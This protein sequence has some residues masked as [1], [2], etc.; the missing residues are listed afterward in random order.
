M[1][2]ALFALL[3][4]LGG[5]GGV[6]LLFWPGVGLVERWRRLRQRSARIQTEDALKYL[7]KAELEGQPVSTTELAGVLQVSPDH[8]AAL[9]GTMRGRG[10][11]A[12]QGDRPQLTP[13]G[14]SHALHIVR[15][16]R[17]WERHLADRTGF[18]EHE[19][20]AQAEHVEHLLTP[21]DVR[22]LSAD[23]GYPTHDPHGDPIPGD[24]GAVVPHAGRPLSVLAVDQ[25][26]RIVHVE[27]EPAAVYAQLVAEGLRP[28]MVGRIVEADPD[29]LLVW[30]DGDVHVLAPIL[31]HNVSVVPLADAAEAEPYAA[32]KL[33]SLRPGEGG[34]VVRLSRACRG[35][36]RRR[37]LDLGLT[38][39][40]DVAAELRST[41]GGPTA[42]RIRG[43]LIALRRDQADRI[44]IT[45]TEASS[46]EATSE[47]AGNHEA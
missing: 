38:P 10:L 8:A 17:L 2:D 29:R 25:A 14:R 45:R 22:L 47:P 30:A 40:T 13:E 36:E 12:W 39:G 1:P 33:S 42:Y 5:L 32:E 20:H 6:V 19:W 4:A 18:G 16:H 34:R 7:F 44:H 31:A 28:G 27:D 15:A 11:I 26:F 43:A 41:G 21:A 37:L 24:D 3:A 9:L 23:L 35:A 46:D